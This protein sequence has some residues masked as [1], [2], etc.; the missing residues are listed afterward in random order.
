[1]EGKANLKFFRMSAQKVRLVADLV[2]GKDINEA[3]NILAFTPK[4][5]SEVISKLLKSAVANADQTGKVDV[6]TLFVKAITVDEGP[7]F[8]PRFRPRAQGRATPILKRTSHIHV[9]LEE[10]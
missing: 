3:L 6:D 9:T 7:T 4:K 5:A 10:R 2:R 8:P 1:M